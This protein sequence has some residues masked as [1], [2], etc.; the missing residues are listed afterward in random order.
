MPADG[1][2]ILGTQRH[3]ALLDRWQGTACSTCGGMILE[4]QRRDDTQ[5]IDL[6][7]MFDAARSDSPAVAACREVRS[8]HHGPDLNC[9][10]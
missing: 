2:V 1:G 9:T 8:D 3:E 6:Q 4:T 5:P 10:W 7:A